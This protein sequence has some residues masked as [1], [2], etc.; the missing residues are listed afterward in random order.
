M[1]DKASLI[2][3]QGESSIRC[4]RFQR[5]GDDCL[6]S[7]QGSWSLESGEVRFAHAEWKRFLSANPTASC[8]RFSAVEL[9]EWDSA[10]IVFLNECRQDLSELKK[11]F[12]TA[13]L[14]RGIARLLSLSIG[15]KAGKPR[16]EFNLNRSIDYLET[17]I[18]RFR[19][20]AKGVA[21][22]FGE[23]ITG[24]VSAIGGRSSMR[25]RDLFSV[26]RSCGA[27]ALPIVTLISF[28]TGLTMAFVGS[29]Q[30]EKF[31]AKIY[32]ADL[33]C[34]AM[35]REMGALMVAIVMAG[36]TGAAFAAELGSMK[37][38]E[39]IDSLRTFGISPMQFLVL[40]RTIGLLL[41]IPLLTLYADMVGILG[42]LAVG[43]QV[44]DFSML[45]YFEQTQTA[46][47]GMWEVYSGLVKSLVF[48]L[49][50][51]LVGC[52]KGLASGKDSASLGRSVTSAVVTSVTLIVVADA[53][54]EM[55][56][57]YLDLR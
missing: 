14:P 32:V 47:G 30:L 37:L 18:V 52:Y 9:G 34:L 22:F 46:L 7:L 35:V 12:D 2:K 57:S 42:G 11:E 10:L 16:S 21:A 15:K 6:C 56:F 27:S 55:A 33:V 4:V 3:K 19:D 54:F 8:F 45:H 48:G 31:N 44:M 26:C 38:N 17:E 1:S 49:I 23:W 40:P 5:E 20:R 29:V 13:G 43:T 51:G 41:M 53:L 50:I 25:M 24:F 39:E 28:L 36:R